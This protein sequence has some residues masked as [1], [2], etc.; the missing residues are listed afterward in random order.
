MNLIFKYGYYFLSTMTLLYAFV[1]VCIEY[2]LYRNNQKI[3]RENRMINK[4]AKKGHNFEIK[5]EGMNYHTAKLSIS[6]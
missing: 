2:K 3:P 5:D 4:R 1:E 6:S